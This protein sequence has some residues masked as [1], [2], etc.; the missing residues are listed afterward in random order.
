MISSQSWACSGRFCQIGK[1][2]LQS[3][4]P[5]SSSAF[6]LRE[7][8]IKAWTQVTQ[9]WRS[10]GSICSRGARELPHA[11]GGSQTLPRT[12]AVSLLCLLLPLDV[13]SDSGIE[14]RPLHS[15]SLL[16]C[17][18]DVQTSETTSQTLTIPGPAF[19]SLRSMECKPFSLSL[20]SSSSK[21]QVWLR[22]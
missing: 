15:Q 11:G 10:T 14:P 3:F 13:Y 16:H 18:C 19:C 8:N 5:W 20:R 17:L 2:P 7:V 6:S 21:E 22:V 12:T 4:F 1:C 9:L